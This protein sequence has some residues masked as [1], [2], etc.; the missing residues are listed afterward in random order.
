MAGCVTAPHPAIDQRIARFQA[1]RVRCAGLRPPLT[2]GLGLPSSC[3]VTHSK[4]KRGTIKELVKNKSKINLNPSW[5]RGTAWKLPRQV[6]LIDS[7][8][9]GMD[10][11]KVYLR[12]LPPGNAHTHDAVDGQQRLRAI[13]EFRAGQYSLEYPEP[14]API[15]IHPV[16]GVKFGDL[17]KSLRDKFES[18]TV[19]VAAITNATNDEITN[20]FSRL[21]MGVSL[22]PAELRNAIL[23]PMRHVIDSIATSHEFFLESRI[24]DTRYKRQDYLAH[25]FA[26]GAYKGTKDIKAPDLKRMVTEFGPDKADQLLQVTSVVGDALNVLAKVNECIDYR[27]TQKW[28]FVDLCWLIMQQ[29]TSGGIVD[30]GDLAESYSEFEKLRRTY[31]SHPEDLIKTAEGHPKEIKLNRHLYNYIIAFRAQG[32]THGNLKTRNAALR[33]FCL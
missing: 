7:I 2:P 23:S 15:G 21:Q 31:N 11:P 20:L 28:I 4:F 17:H 13:W 29:Q 26:M 8:L 32:A 1:S 27:I 16:A 25:I 33:A 30:P 19:S 5:Q 22:N 12:S 10:I 9:R 3:T 14:L 6:L 18:F 24:P